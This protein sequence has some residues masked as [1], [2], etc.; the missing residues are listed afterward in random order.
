MALTESEKHAAHRHALNNL[1]AQL[2][3]SSHPPLRVRSPRELQ[4]HSVRLS[5]LI[6]NAYNMRLRP[7]ADLIRSLG[8]FCRGVDV[9]W[10]T[11]LSGESAAD[12]LIRLAEESPLLTRSPR[13][14]LS[15][16]ALQQM[17]SP[18]VRS[19]AAM[20]GRGGSDKWRR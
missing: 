9:G 14:P 1:V 15:A 3:R 6:E 20:D 18:A 5:E 8:E 19:P 11:V 2:R 10:T 7:G 16:S 12:P 13:H 17:P 4:K